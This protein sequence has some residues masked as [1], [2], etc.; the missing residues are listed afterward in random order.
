[1]TP[2]QIR[3]RELLDTAH[4]RGIRPH[5]CPRCGDR[6]GN[7]QPGYDDH[8]DPD[9]VGYQ[10]RSCGAVTG[11]TRRTILRRARPR[12]QVQQWP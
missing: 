7:W 8:T 2:D 5:R 6:T 4:A 3:Y 9:Y 11:L 1:M 10:C 12:R